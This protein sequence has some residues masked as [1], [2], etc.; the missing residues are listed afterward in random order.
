MRESGS[1]KTMKKMFA[2]AFV[3]FVGFA[4]CQQE[5]VDPDAIGSDSLKVYATI[6]D[7]DDTKTSLNDREVYWTSGDRIAIFINKT[8][9]KRFE[10]S[11]ESVGTKEGTFLYDSDYIVTGKSVAISNNV[12]YYPFCEVTCAVSGSTYTLSNVTI[13]TTQD[14]APA[15][16]G[17]G[18]FPMV[19]VTADT[20][21][22]D[23]AFRNLC[24]VLSLQLKGSGTI[25]SITVKGNSDE[26]LSGKATVTAS[27]GKT[28]EISLLSGG[29]KT[30]TLDCG[31]SGVELQSDTPTSFFIVLPPVSFDN[32]FTVTV[33]D[34]SGATKEYSTTKKNTILRSGILRMPEKEYVGE[35]VPQEGD[36][37]DE[38]GI[39]HGQGVKIGETVWAPVNC[40]YHK[41]NFKYGK[42]YQ[43]GRKY[44]QGYDG[45]LYD[46]D[47]NYLGYYSD[48]Y[49]PEKVSGPVS[50]STGQS[51]ANEDKFYYNSSSPYDWLYP[52]DDALWNAGTYYAPV[53]TEYDPCPEGWRV[54]TN[55]ELYELRNNYSSWITADNGQTGRWF[56]GPNSYTASVPQVF[57]PAAAS[58]SFYDG[59]AYYRGFFA[60]YWSSR[61]NYNDAYYLGFE[62]YNVGMN[63]SNRANGYSVRCVQDATELIPVERVILNKT[64]LTLSEG[65]S[66]GISATI[67]PLNANHQ[68]AH[69]WSDDESVAVVD[70][71]GNVTAV[72]EGTTIIYAMAGMQVAACEVN[73]KSD[74][75]SGDYIDEYGVN[76][77]K[78]VAIGMAIWAPVNCGYHAT[79][80]K[81]G[82]LYQWGRKYGQGY[83]ENDA[84][85]PTIEDG[86]ISVI[87][88]QHKNKANV[89]FTS[90]V[91]YNNDWLYPQDDALWNSGS[92]S[93]PLKTEYDPCPE[94]WRVPTY[95]ELD[96][97]SNNYS[98]MTTADNGQMGRWFSGPNS[99]TATIPQ[100][101]FPA[102]GFRSYD[103][104]DAYNRGYGGNY[105]SSRPNG[106]RASDLGFGNSNVNMYNYSRA[107]GCSVRCVQV[108]D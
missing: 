37:I 93:N 102:A 50:L 92:E 81:Y 17:Q 10:V 13:P 73:V 29:D 21:D 96:E 45:E 91:E 98:S 49:V 39:N 57:F 6:E 30:V 41:D 31:E 100:V 8:L 108:T 104:G 60:Y 32:G 33:T 65:S 15:S 5:L 12:A 7:A 18:A 1:M 95:A 27:Y 94:G 69:W 46:G 85:V 89:F 107:N 16:F 101:F 9:R 74:S 67:T 20:D 42:L 105:W 51:K 63:S 26:L 106:T 77:G 23:F 28:P 52:Q 2:M 53:K 70:Q 62:S 99:Y 76:H 24:G 80:F 88:G 36:Y 61:P 83:D 48:S 82:K 56:S 59:G 72:S 19:A 4:G 58:R 43:W 14:Y 54:P 66:E 11:S 25:K 64:S 40:G 103:D 34:A 47:L 97:L 68:S 90:S 35:R 87:T 71:S 75:K 86:G 38:Y 78:G 44:G 3:A 22:L 55:A 79:D 84:S